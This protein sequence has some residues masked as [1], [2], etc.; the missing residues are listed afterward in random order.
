M[1][2]EQSRSAPVGAIVPTMDE[3]MPSRAKLRAVIY[4]P[5]TITWAEW[6]FI[7]VVTTVLLL[8]TSL[9][10]VF[11]GLTVP[12]NK[13]F[14]GVMLDAPD[15]FQYFSWMREL[16]QAH[17][18]ANKLTPEA[19]PPA[20]FNLLWW[21][22]GRLGA[23]LNLDYAAV[24]QV[25]R[26]VSAVLY[27]LAAYLLISWFITD[28]YK[29]KVAFLLGALMSGFGW[30]LVVMKY[31]VA[32]GTLPY[33]LGVYIA[34]GNTFLCML[35]Y[36]HFLAAAV[37]VVVF[38]LFLRGY[39]EQRWRYFYIAGFV[40]L[41]LGWQHAYDLTLVYGILFAFIGLLFVRERRLPWG[42]IFGTVIIGILSWWPA[43]YSVL[44]TTFSP[45]WK[46]V[47]AQFKN[48]G[49]YTPDLLRLP[50]L[51]GPAF[52][53]AVFVALLDRPWKLRGKSDLDLMLHA[54][55]WATFLLIYLPVDYQIHFLNGWQIPIAI[56]A[57]RGLFTYVVPWAQRVADRFGRQ[58]KRL[59]VRTGVVFCAFALVVPTNVYLFAWRF[60]ELGRYEYPYFL[61]TD[62]V[63]A[64]AWLEANVTPD[65]VVLSSLTVGQYVPAMTGAHAFLAHWAQTVDFYTKTELVEQFYSAETPAV[66]QREILEAYAVDYVILGPAERVLGPGP[67]DG[68]PLTEVFSTPLVKVY[69]TTLDT[70]AHLTQ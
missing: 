11:A 36:P 57:T 26:V 8:L 34:E 40:A 46:E 60:V 55:F 58:R 1:A 52:L 63:S 69:A 5:P 54:W 48:A 27:L 51:L 59:A 9:P 30:V 20:F 31:T 42:A 38:D 3:K 41:V 50:I 24:Y 4:S 7:L 19:N 56:L 2:I 15:H 66:R 43:L 25:L 44:L 14:M 61:H 47:L 21:S 37:Y 13:Q 62:E 18:A 16:S 68:V 35:G 32:N 45:T 29:R 12:P 23:L 64:L 53:L 70:K 10:Y 28:S 67:E 6:R 65:D 17:L 49:V 33:P 22:L 39:L